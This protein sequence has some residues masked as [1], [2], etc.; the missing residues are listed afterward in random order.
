M[1]AN[2]AF[3]RVTGSWVGSSSQR[4]SPGQILCSDTVA[5]ACTN[6]HMSDVDLTWVDSDNKPHSNQSGVAFQC[7]AVSGG[8]QHNVTPHG[9]LG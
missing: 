5:E 2:V 1:I 8:Q 3:E 6:I 4:Y 9:C 7:W